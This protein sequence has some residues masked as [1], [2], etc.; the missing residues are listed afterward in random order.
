MHTHGPET[1]KIDFGRKM[2]KSMTENK[3]FMTKIKQPFVSNVV[4][5]CQVD[6]VVE[7]LDESDKQ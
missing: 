2:L 1:E 7:P 5:H 3:K 4:R 6:Y